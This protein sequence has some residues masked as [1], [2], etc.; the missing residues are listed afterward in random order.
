[1]ASR[2]FAK[3]LA[4]FTT[5]L[6]TPSTAPVGSPAALV[7]GGMAWKAR[8]RYEEPSTRT[9][10]GLD[11]GGYYG[12]KSW[13]DSKL[14]RARSTTGLPGALYLPMRDSPAAAIA[15]NR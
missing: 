7:S 11:I 3:S 1:M 8:Y 4:S 13:Q 2:A 6:S 15:T 14:Y 12:I 9:R 10:V 5:M